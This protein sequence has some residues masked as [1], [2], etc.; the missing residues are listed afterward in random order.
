MD[1]T[2]NEMRFTQEA[3]PI[4]ERSSSLDNES[5]SLATYADPKLENCLLDEDHF[6]RELD[7][8]SSRRW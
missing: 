6:V 4:E 5:T 2:T 3:S 1:S 8:L 7:N